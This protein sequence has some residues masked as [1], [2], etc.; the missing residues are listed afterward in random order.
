MNDS[1]MIGPISKKLRQRLKVFMIEFGHSY[2][3]GIEVLLDMMDNN[4]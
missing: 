1:T 2:E 4:R 3:A